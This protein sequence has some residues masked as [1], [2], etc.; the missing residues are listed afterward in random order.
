MAHPL[1]RASGALG[2]A[3]TKAATACL[4]VDENTS[5]RSDCPTHREGGRARPWARADAD[6]M[7]GPRAVFRLGIARA[8]LAEADALPAGRRCFR[9]T[10]PR[11]R[12]MRRHR[13]AICQLPKRC[14]RSLLAGTEPNNNRS[15]S[16]ASIATANKIVRQKRACSTEMSRARERNSRSGCELVVVDFAL[17]NWA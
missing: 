17:R 1:T 12:Q 16:A 11:I 14:C 3:A 13:V 5:G 15:A 6:R 10:Q 9:G 8:T 4:G 7:A 2:S